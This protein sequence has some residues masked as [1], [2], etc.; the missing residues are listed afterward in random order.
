MQKI[1]SN[2][3]HKP[4]QPRIGTTRVNKM[5]CTNKT[6][7]SGIWYRFRLS[8]GFWREKLSFFVLTQQSNYKRIWKQLKW[9]QIKF[10]FARSSTWA[11]FTFR[12]S[13]FL[14]LCLPPPSVL[15]LFFCGALRRWKE[16]LFVCLSF[17]LFSGLRK[18]R[19]EN[20]QTQNAFP[21]HDSQ[22]LFRYR[23]FSSLRWKKGDPSEQVKVLP[24]D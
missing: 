11:N 7:I 6:W 21:I 24:T 8:F 22:L 23:K 3:T 2:P 13:S 10:P 5:R 20:S 9:R 15:K 18:K 14:S 1:Y 4:P 19:V 17:M 12:F 16:K